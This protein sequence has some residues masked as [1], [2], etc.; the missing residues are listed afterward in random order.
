MD[1]QI[2]YG[3]VL[4][5]NSVGSIQKVIHFPP[6]WGK[7]PEEGILWIR[8]LDSGSISKGLNFFKDL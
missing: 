3:M 5:C 1:T 2:S 4:L 7:A 6:H 8:L